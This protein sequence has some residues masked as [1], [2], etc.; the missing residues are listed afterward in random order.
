MCSR[1][2]KELEGE[3]EKISQK[4]QKFSRF[5][6]RETNSL[7][8]Q[9]IEDE[10]QFICM[11]IEEKDQEIVRLTDCVNKAKQESINL[12]S[13]MTTEVH[14][15]Q[16]EPPSPTYSGANL[17]C[18]RRLLSD[19]GSTGAWAA[20]Q[21]S[22]EENKAHFASPDPFESLFPQSTGETLQHN[23]EEPAT[24]PNEYSQSFEERKYENEEEK[25]EVRKKTQSKNTNFYMS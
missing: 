24:P 19:V 10:L 7:E 12:A 8:I 23:K 14:S 2:E 18:N 21:K 13:L 3:F 20:H 16:P 17:Q 1:L 4:A 22:L 9:D 11:E 15:S 6:P 5:Q 25:I